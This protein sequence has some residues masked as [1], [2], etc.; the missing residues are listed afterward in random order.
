MLRRCPVHDHYI[1]Q[2]LPLCPQSARQATGRFPFAPDESGAITTCAGGALE[3]RCTYTSVDLPTATEQTRVHHPPLL[4]ATSMPTLF[5]YPTHQHHLQP[6]LPPALLLPNIVSTPILPRFPPARSS[7]TGPAFV[8]P[9]SPPFQFPTPPTVANELAPS[10][11]PPPPQLS[12]EVCRAHISPALPLSS[13]SSSSVTAG[14]SLQTPER[15]QEPNS[16]PSYSYSAL[17]AMAITASP[18]KMAT[19]ADICRYITTTFPYYKDSDKSW[20]RSIRQCLTNNDCFKKAPFAPK[21]IKHSRNN[22][23]VI[24]PLSK[25]M[26]LKGGFRSPRD[27]KRPREVEEA[28]RVVYI[29]N[30]NTCI[31][32]LVPSV[33]K[34]TQA[35][36]VLPYH[37]S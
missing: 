22:Y 34:K 1:P 3:T 27:R 4:S 10:H 20:K 17:I 9:F 31:T 23:W 2:L 14:P 21:E 19:L 35:V 18:H 12:L 5:Q 24:D 7:P 30:K 6:E 11:S 28:D 37:K 13:G 8:Y 33:V 26:F 16:K 32:E 36:C 25:K 29:P 15:M